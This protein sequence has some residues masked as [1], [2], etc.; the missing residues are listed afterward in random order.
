MN[1]KQALEILMMEQ[2]NVDDIAIK[3]AQE[4]LEKALSE[5]KSYRKLLSSFAIKWDKEK[6]QR[7][8]LV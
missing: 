8:N 2:K 4:L 5:L 3:E 1:E 7:I 6:G